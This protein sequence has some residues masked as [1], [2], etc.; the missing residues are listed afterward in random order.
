MK[1]VTGTLYEG[2]LHLD[3]K[4]FSSAP[5]VSGVLA[6][7]TSRTGGS[8][9]LKREAH[10]TNHTS[11]LALLVASSHVSNYAGLLEL[12]REYSPEVSIFACVSVAFVLRL[13]LST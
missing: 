6:N 13:F 5:S 2:H 8:S 4:Y 10:Q 12:D 7:I 11:D 3:L 1:N 9:L